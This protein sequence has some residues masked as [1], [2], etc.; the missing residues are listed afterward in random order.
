[1]F[2][3]VRPH[4]PPKKENKKLRDYFAEEFSFLHCIYVIVI[5]KSNDDTL[6]KCLAR[7]EKSQL[8]VEF[9]FIGA[10]LSNS[11]FYENKK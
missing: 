10:I 8:L 1:M 7:Y 3:R 9:I 4:P 6:N 11:N 2:T 5:Y